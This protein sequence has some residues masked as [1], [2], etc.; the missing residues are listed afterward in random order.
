MK[1]FW[2]PTTMRLFP[3]N[4]TWLKDSVVSFQP[5]KEMSLVGR[6]FVP[7][8]FYPVT[9]SV[10]TPTLTTPTHTITNSIIPTHINTPALP[11]H[12]GCRNFVNWL[13]SDQNC[14]PSAE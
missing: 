1:V 4:A 12:K 9:E 7:K 11:H 3:R 14:L 8:L 10:T 13:A 5:G 2:Q 6:D